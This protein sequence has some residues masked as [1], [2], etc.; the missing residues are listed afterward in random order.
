VF[1]DNQGVVVDGLVDPVKLTFEPTQIDEE[2]VI[3]GNGLTIKFAVLTHP[4]LSV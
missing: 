1:E 3:I 2:P 4:L